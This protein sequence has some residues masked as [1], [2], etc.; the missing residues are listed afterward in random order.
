MDNLLIQ[1][2]RTMASPAPSVMLVKIRICKDADA[3]Q[4]RLQGG[5][6]NDQMG[7]RE[8]DEQGQRRH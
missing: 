8:V 7:K 6:Y 2:P 5:Q 1:Y 3:E 4:I